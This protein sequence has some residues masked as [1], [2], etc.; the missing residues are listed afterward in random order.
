[1]LQCDETT[2]ACIECTSSGR[3]CDGPLGGTLFVDMSAKVRAAVD[4]ASDSNTEERRRPKARSVLYGTSDTKELLR[5]KCNS[6]SIETIKIPSTYQPHK[7][8]IFQ[9]HYIAHFMK[10]HDSCIHSW[11]TQLPNIISSPACSSEIYA[12]RAATMAFYSKVTGREDIELEAARWY[13]RGLESQRKYIQSGPEMLDDENCISRAVF[14]AILFS[15][16]ETIICTNPTGWIHHFTAAGK[17]LQL[18]GPKSCQRG[19]MHSFFRSVRIASVHLKT[20][21]ICHH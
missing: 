12:I 20:V 14:A 7:A 4:V 19:L 21:Y 10:S 8:E 5:T 11:I 15:T 3:E 2:P 17:L 18:A 6:T 1:M 13:S 9:L 16:F